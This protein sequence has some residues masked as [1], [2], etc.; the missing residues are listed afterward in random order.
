MTLYARLLEIVAFLSCAG[1]IYAILNQSSQR[2]E[3]T[4]YP[5]TEVYDVSPFGPLTSKYNSHGRAFS[6]VACNTERKTTT[7][8]TQLFQPVVIT[9]EVVHSAHIS[10][11]KSLIEYI[12]NTVSFVFNSTC[13][14][15]EAEIYYANDFYSS[16]HFAEYG[17]APCD[18]YASS[19]GMLEIRVFYANDT[20]RVVVIRK[21]GAAKG[22]FDTTPA[23]QNDALA[24]ES[25]IYAWYD[26]SLNNIN[27]TASQM[28]IDVH[29]HRLNPADDLSWAGFSDVTK[30]SLLSIILENGGGGWYNGLSA[31]CQFTYPPGSETKFVG[32]SP[33]ETV[34]IA[35]GYAG[36]VVLPVLVVLEV[37][38]ILIARARGKND[39]RGLLS[40]E[41]GANKSS[42]GAMVS[43][44][45]ARNGSLIF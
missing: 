23:N 44:M 31:R 20:Q 3:T 35:L 28:V 2:Y 36:I 43:D 1:V 5:L 18:R 25:F 13:P 24:G 32:L 7:Y 22:L 27:F 21:T 11:S 16:A 14:T 10:T 40:G 9:R 37:V 4:I 6:A 34:G 45:P 29:I 41:T 15:G 33:S 39:R 38:F 17:T 30:R 26:P 8:T 12:P 19:D 42:L